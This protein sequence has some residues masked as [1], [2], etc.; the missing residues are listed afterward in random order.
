[1]G[2]EATAVLHDWLVKT[3]RDALRAAMMA[4]DGSIDA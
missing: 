1:M 2:G 4:E 3:P